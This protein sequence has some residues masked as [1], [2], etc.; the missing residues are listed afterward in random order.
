MSNFITKIV[1][2][3]FVMTLCGESAFAQTRARKV[4][5]TVV[6]LASD[7]AL[8]H[9]TETRD[10]WDLLWAFNVKPVQGWSGNFS[11]FLWEDK[12]Y[13]TKWEEKDGVAYRFERSGDTW[14]AD[15]S[16]TIKG[17]SYGDVNAE[18]FCT[19][20]EFLYCC[21][22]Y[23]TIFRIDPATWIAT[24][25]CTVGQFIDGIA[26][27]ADHDA[28]WIVAYEYNEAQRV[29][30]T[31]EILKTLSCDFRLVDV[32]WEKSSDGTPY[33]WASIKDD[34]GQ[35]LHRWD[36]TTDTFQENAKS[37]SG[38]PNIGAG[39]SGAGLFTG[40]D[41]VIEKSVLIGI[42]ESTTDI[43]YCFDIDGG[44]E[45]CP[46]V[47][48]LKAEVQGLDV[49]LTWTA[50]ASN[51]TG[52]KV[53]Q[54]PALLAIVT[55]TEYVFRDL[56]NGSYK[57]SVEAV[58]NDNC[59]SVKETT[60]VTIKKSKPV[61][62]L[63]GSCDG[64]LTLAWD[65][66]EIDLGYEG[67]ISH[68]L[69]NS[70]ADG[71][72]VNDSYLPAT[73]GYYSRW[74]VADMEDI[75][76]TSGSV[77]SK[78]QFFPY[79]FNGYT[80][81][82]QVYQG[83]DSPEN[84]GQLIGESPFSTAD[85]VEREW[86]TIPLDD[87]IKIDASKEFWFGLELHQTVASNF[88]CLWDSGPQAFQRNVA[89]WISGGNDGWQDLTELSPYYI[90]NFMLKG[91][92]S[93][94]G[95]SIISD[96]KTKADVIKY[97]IYQ[98]DVY[99][100]E[101]TTTTFTKTGITGKHLYC[102]VA[103]YDNGAQSPK[104]CKEIDCGNTPPPPPPPTCDKVTGAK[105]EIAECKTA[106]VTWTAVEGA[107]GY[108][109]ND[110]PVETNAYTETGDFEHGKTYIWTIVTVCDDGLESNPVTVSA[111]GDCEPIESIVELGNN[112]AIYPNPTSGTI[113]IHATNFAKVEIYNTVGQL[114][115]TKNVPSFDIATYNAG[116][117]FF[118][119]YDAHN[120]SVTKR[121]MV[122]K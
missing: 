120:N 12:L 118:K 63:N 59:I 116:V 115:E 67:W 32:A 26:Y 121:V 90:G 37:L 13:I 27:D 73:Y 107:V 62:N 84:P 122:T 21:T 68:C 10:P 7:P 17:L 14:V 23:G 69:S 22:G 101:T 108:K 49:K 30:R 66:P 103:V 74:T 85:L 4:E 39:V 60:Q 5:S 114:V 109:V 28:F 70:F 8:V 41:P 61:Q 64:T 58:Y 45:P 56:S 57:F 91:E 86:N 100:G 77:L 105:A 6:T 36:L 38:V 55:V 96:G 11:P 50:A 102:V 3:A 97:V 99:F 34:E 24:I 40:Y 89:H 43:V 112:V 93:V 42:V 54:G 15:G 82:I 33:L 75:G 104:V 98:D 9:S 19:D 94:G 65:E 2:M 31:G 79:S 117:Y 53:Y 71:L 110:K 29:S 87:P 1:I 95:K 119:V 51:P 46:A 80:M 111:T 113:T 48:D 92:I 78:I 88:V 76:I 16:V 18:G 52:Y 25:Q 47:T 83:G 106:T 81:T 35:N 20:G 44:G 72:C